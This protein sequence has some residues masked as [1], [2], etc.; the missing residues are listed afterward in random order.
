M[1]IINL[2]TFGDQIKFAL[3][4]NT[5]I[6]LCNSKKNCNFAVLKYTNLPTAYFNSLVN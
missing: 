2:M 4:Y 6:A 3:K 1:F 5:K